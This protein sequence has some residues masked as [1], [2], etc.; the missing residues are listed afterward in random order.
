MKLYIKLTFVS[1]VSLVSLI[2]FLW[3][4]ESESK[5]KE[6]VANTYRP[7]FT[8][9]FELSSDLDQNE[10]YTRGKNLN[11]ID[12]ALLDN[13][14]ISRIYTIDKLLE[15]YSSTIVD[16]LSDSEVGILVDN[17]K[18]LAEK[19]IVGAMKK[20]KFSE[21]KK[22]CLVNSILNHAKSFSKYCNDNRELPKCSIDNLKR[23]SHIM[24]KVTSLN[25]SMIDR[26]ANYLTSEINEYFRNSPIIGE[27][28][29]Y[30]RKYFD[31]NIR[32]L[33]MAYC[34][35]GFELGS[36]KSGLV[37]AALYRQSVMKSDIDKSKNLYNK[38]VIN[39]TTGEAYYMLGI[40]QMN[41]S[42]GAK[43][44]I[45]GLCNLKSAAQLKYKKA[46]EELEFLMI[47]RPSYTKINCET[48]S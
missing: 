11:L 17:Y 48:E 29:K 46:I 22:S 2:G 3:Y 9:I 19:E 43:N 33:A 31:S 44:R 27:A 6:I 30:C 1:L 34:K 42:K 8:T 25:Q 15:I 13:P 16:S 41:K 4:L 45:I 35:N 26:S 21:H 47:K 20:C 14:L 24:S 39:D 12:I 23:S 36:V 10:I 28:D 37:L 5:L 40:M 38:L 18:S 7:M 32:F